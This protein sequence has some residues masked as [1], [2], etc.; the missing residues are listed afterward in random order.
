MSPEQVRG[1]TLDPRSDLFS[2][3]LEDVFDI[4]ERIS[5][6]IVEALQMK[7][8]PREDRR[9]AERQ[10]TNVHAYECYQQARRDIYTFTEAGLDRA[11]RLIQDALDLVGDNELLY[12]ALG[13]VYWQY[14]NAAIRPDDG[15][16]DM[17]AECAEKAFR[18]NPESA[19]G[20]LLRGLVQLARGRPLEALKDLKHAVAIEPNNAQALQ[21]LAR[22]YIAAG[23]EREARAAIDRWL[24]TDPLSPARQPVV[25]G[26]EFFCGTVE[27]AR[28]LAER[29][30]ETGPDHAMLQFWHAL[31]LVQSD[32]LD[33]ARQL[34][35]RTPE[36]RIPTVAGGCC[37]FLA[38]ALDERRAEA[39]ASISG[40]MKTGARRV[41]VW[42]FFLAEC[43][44]FL[45]D[46]DQAMDWLEN[47][48][49]LGF[50]PYPFLAS[51]EVTLA[52]FRGQPRYDTLMQK[53]KDAWE[54]FPG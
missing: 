47:A 49:R 5:R 30:L 28:V 38:H 4:Q 33:E 51:R 6:Q 21:E 24:A 22:V 36:E 41:E 32:R 44:G 26:V 53:I 11:R 19:A 27:R 54:H 12:A 35:A 42:S 14:V 39:L 16:L 40:D 2:G 23:Q 46:A 31:C 8:S 29:M 50:S 48:L 25:F 18:I 17:A 9:L 1:E 10:I 37:R 3:R 34:L 7:L 13:A 20:F 45:G 15:L 52:K 43:Y